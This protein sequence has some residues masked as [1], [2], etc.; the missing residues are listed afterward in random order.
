MLE[1]SF[2]GRNIVITEGAGG[3]WI[4]LARELLQLGAAR[5]VLTGRDRARLASAAENLG[6]RVETAGFDMTDEG[7][8]AGF[9]ARQSTI[10]RLITAAA[11][12]MRGLVAELEVAKARVLFELKYWGQ[13]SCC[14]QGMVKLAPHGSIVPFSGWISRKPMAGV[15][16]IAAIDA[17]MEALGRTFAFEIAPR[18]VNSGCPARSTR[19][20][21]R[22]VCR[23]KSGRRTSRRLA[24]ACPRTVRALLKTPPMPCA[25]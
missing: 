1:Q 4:A 10:D 11:G 18:R 12:T 16:A 2:D 20:S 25:S 22:P 17:V 3:I 19:Q 5:V 6:P 24:R 15:L 8:M 21:G 9:L 13:C 23:P 7:H 14:K